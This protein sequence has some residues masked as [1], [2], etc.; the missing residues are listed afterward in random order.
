MENVIILKDIS[1]SFEDK[2]VFDSFSAEISENTAI[3]GA[4]GSGKTTLIK[5]ITGLANNYGGSVTFL[6]KPSFSAVFQEDRLFDDYSAVANVLAV[7]PKNLPK[8]EAENKARK[9]LNALLISENEMKKP[10]RFFSGGMKRRVAIARALF[11]ESDI[12]LLDEPYKGLDEE[13]KARAA[14]VIR[15]FAENRLIVLVTHDK[16]EA[17][18][19]G[20]EK[21][22][23]I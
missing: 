4:S 6:E 12:L 21:V 1:L 23:K 22:I 16:S 18:M 9:L 14:E 13:T 8:S 19:T 17:E 11:F 5:I 7:A 3:M 15:T 2:T 20:I 10:V